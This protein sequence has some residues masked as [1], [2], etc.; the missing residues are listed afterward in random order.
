MATILK[1]RQPRLL[2][3][4]CMYC[5]DIQDEQGEWRES[6][7][8]LKTINVSHGICPDCLENVAI[9]Q[10]LDYLAQM[11]AEETSVKVA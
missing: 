5:K 10:L 6:L 9:P 3:T 1:S 11:P 8:K 4:V 7:E 2:T